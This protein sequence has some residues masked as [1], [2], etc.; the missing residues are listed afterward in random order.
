[1]VS[2]FMDAAAHLGVETHQSFSGI[3]ISG[4]KNGDGEVVYEQRPAFD[5]TDC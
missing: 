5:W 2:E 3:I 4:K 1:V